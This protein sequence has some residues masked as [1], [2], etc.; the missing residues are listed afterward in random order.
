MLK[1]SIIEFKWFN[2]LVL[3]EPQSQTRK[4]IILINI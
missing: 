4:V 1:T 3:K 2:I